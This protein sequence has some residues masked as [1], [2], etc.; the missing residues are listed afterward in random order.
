MTSSIPTNNQ[1]I[2][3]AKR[4]CPSLLSD[5]N[6][7]FSQSARSY[8]ATNVHFENALKALNV[9]FAR[10]NVQSDAENVKTILQAMEKER[11]SPEPDNR[12]FYET[13]CMA[14]NENEAMITI[15]LRRLYLF[16]FEIDRA[17][18]AK[19]R[20][21]FTVLMPRGEALVLSTLDAFQCQ[22]RICVSQ[23]DAP[24]LIR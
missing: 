15:R 24:Y 18:I 16:L 9:K 23:S 13:L 1:S 12:E 5:L 17:I 2:I 14:D 10:R 21:C 22:V 20:I 3:S 4:S 8:I 19:L 6:S 7:T 11:D